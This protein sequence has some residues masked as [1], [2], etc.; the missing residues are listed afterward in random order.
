[1][2]VPIAVMQWCSTGRGGS[3]SNSSSSQWRQYQH[4]LQKQRSG[5]GGGGGSCC[6]ASFRGSGE[7]GGVGGR[8]ML[9]TKITT[10]S[11]SIT[12]T[13]ERNSETVPQSDVCSSGNDR[14]K[15]RSCTA[16]VWARGQ[17]SVGKVHRLAVAIWSKCLGLP[18]TRPDLREAL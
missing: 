16:A 13:I 8:R 3:S 15:K 17:C 9:A 12:T 7:E 1:M 18:A 2:V 4:Q 14:Q 5:S 6:R 10:T 11:T